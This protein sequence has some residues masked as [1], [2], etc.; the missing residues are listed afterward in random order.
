MFIFHIWGNDHPADITKRKKSINR[1][2]FNR[3]DRL[4]LYVSKRNRECSFPDDEDEREVFKYEEKLPVR[5]NGYTNLY[6]YDTF[7]FTNMDV[8]IKTGT[9]YRLENK[10]LTFY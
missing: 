6:E 9:L 7:C 10:I 1:R 2:D 5:L 8:H 4:I 3:N